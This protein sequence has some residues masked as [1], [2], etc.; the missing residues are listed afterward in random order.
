[1]WEFRGVSEQN[2]L[3]HL[4]LVPIDEKVTNHVYKFLFFLPTY[5]HAYF[6]LK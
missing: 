3:K 1:M 6:S 4:D 5:M 2:D